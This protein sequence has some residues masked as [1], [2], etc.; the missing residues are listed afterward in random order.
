M[1]CHPAFFSGQITGNYKMAF[2][3]TSEDLIWK[4]ANG[5]YNER[6][7][8]MINEQFPKTNTFDTRVY[9]RFRVA[10]DTNK[11]GEGMNVHSDITVD[12]WSFVGKTEKF[13]INGVGRDWAELE[14]KYWS[15]TRSAAPLS[16][17]DLAL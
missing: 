7:F 12:P 11:D 6:N 15:G 3:A 5:D 17:R 1:L 14:L 2:G 16:D 9:D 13:T 4:R 8:R 10:F